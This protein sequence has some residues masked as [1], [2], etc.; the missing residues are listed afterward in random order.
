ML[1]YLHYLV[2]SCDY[3]LM[4]LYACVVV[5][6]CGYALVQRLQGV[7]KA[8]RSKPCHTCLM[9]S[10]PAE[11]YP[12]AFLVTLGKGLLKQG[13]KLVTADA[14]V[15]A[16]A[17]DV[18]TVLQMP[19]GNLLGHALHIHLCHLELVGDGCA[20]AVGEIVHVTLEHDVEET[21]EVVLAHIIVVPNPLL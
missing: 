3:A 14:K 1:S 15:R 13:H 12:L 6:L 18:V 11:P 8:H 21:E 19:G 4:R 9:P 2:R 7:G 20:R 10:R 5:R 16:D 17:V